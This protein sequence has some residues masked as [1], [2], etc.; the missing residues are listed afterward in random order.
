MRKTQ[1]MDTEWLSNAIRGLLTG[2]VAAP[3][4][5]LFANTIAFAGKVNSEFPF[6]VLFLPIGAL[7][8]TFIYRKAG[9]KYKKATVYAI[10]EI[11]A[12]ENQKLNLAESQ[13]TEAEVSPIMG[14]I[15]FFTSTFSHMLGASVGKEGVGVQLGLSAGSLL[16]I[17]E[18]KLFRKNNADASS[19]YLMAGASAAFGALFGSPISGV[20]FGIQF[21][22][23][24]F[25]RLDALM[26]CIVSSYTATALSRVLGIHIL[27]IPAITALEVNSSNILSVALFALIIGLISRFFCF[28]LKRFSELNNRIS[29]ESAYKSSIF[30]AIIALL[31]IIANYYLTNSFA[32]NGLSAQLLYS[33]ISDSIPLYA[34]IVKAL[35]VILSISAGFIGGEVVP[36]LVVGSAIGYTA[37]SILS[38]PTSSF[39]ALGALG[40]LS[41]GTN[42][43]LVCFALGLELFHYP[44]PTLLFIAVTVAYVTSGN[45]GIYA[46]QRKFF[47]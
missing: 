17:G 27:T 42:L 12:S 36:L 11:Q 47:R 3:L 41:G 37:A 31:I 29:K 8:I 5:T 20:L 13:N 4:I 2:I 9:D 28:S 38:L 10:D 33:S 32:Y 21:A 16:S 24:S 43:P 40:M 26:P 15:G 30:P 18:R 14:L 39:A 1:L 6:I 23:P 35:L 46:H 34:F 22:S 45:E 44:D 7:I 25:T 19:Y